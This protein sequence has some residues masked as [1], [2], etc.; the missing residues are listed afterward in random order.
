MSWHA[1]S[2][3]YKAKLG[4]P[5]RKAIAA[6][7]ADWADDDGGSIF[8][9]VNRI[10][11][12]TETSE[13]TVQNV[14]KAFRTEK[15][16]IVVEKGGKGPG[17]VTEYR[18]DFEALR[19]LPRS[20]EPDGNKGANAAP[21]ARKRKGA[22]SAP[23]A[24]AKRVQ[25]TTE[26]GAAGAPNLSVNPK[27]EFPTTNAPPGGCG[28]EAEIPFGGMT[29]E[30]G[31]WLLSPP[32]VDEL[33]D[34]GA[35]QAAKE[36][37]GLEFD[38]L[39]VSPKWFRSECSRLLIDPI[40]ILKKY[41]QRAESGERITNPGG[42]LRTMLDEAVRTREGMTPTDVQACSDAINRKLDR[43]ATSAAAR[44]SGDAKSIGDLSAAL[45]RMAG[46]VKR[47]NA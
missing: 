29:D 6:K 33:L 9:S 30:G 8:P 36:A 39:A 12:E 18:L 21:L 44:A 37:T 47:A 35:E 24:G 45:A 15:L 19:K 28:G 46:N 14:L 10:A 42:Y 34:Q 22:K 1:I 7:L 25:L 41:L 27:A 4:G 43:R 17:S 20:R 5:T 26:K 23:L 38:Y 13:R 16:L 3:V 32:T 11:D 31:D 2:E 40:P